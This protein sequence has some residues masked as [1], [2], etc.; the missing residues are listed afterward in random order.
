MM[1]FIQVL[2]IR[3]LSAM[4]LERKVL[5]NRWPTRLVRLMMAKLGCEERFIMLSTEVAW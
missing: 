3:R 2:R 1:I 4:F 5:R